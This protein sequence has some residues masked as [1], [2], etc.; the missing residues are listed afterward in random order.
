[1][2]NS[3]AASTDPLQ[4]VRTWMQSKKPAD[5]KLAV[6]AFPKLMVRL[7]LKEQTAADAA[8]ANSGSTVQTKKLPI[9]FFETARF[10]LDRNWELLESFRNFKCRF[11]NAHAYVLVNMLSHAVIIIISFNRRFAVLMN[12]V[13]VF[14]STK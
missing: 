12:R 1:M 7:W 9:L 6:D 14:S 10:P 2:S 3:A 11:D 4:E 13:Q 8:A 5:I